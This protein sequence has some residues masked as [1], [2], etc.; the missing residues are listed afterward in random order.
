MP[1]PFESSS[2]RW[3]EAHGA[4][5]ASYDRPYDRAR[6]SGGISADVERL[7][8]TPR[9]FALRD[10]VRR[11]DPLCV[12]CLEEGRT[13][14]TEDIDHIVP[15]R[16]LVERGEVARFFD[17]SNLRGLCRPCHARHGAR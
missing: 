15:A 6:R 7:R 4:D 11:R 5:R 2:D 3:R 16:V 17:A 8:H 9:W 13:T 10:Q 1:A 14:P 12:L